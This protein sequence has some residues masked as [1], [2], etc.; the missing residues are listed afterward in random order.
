MKNYKFEIFEKLININLYLNF[1]LM[2][3]WDANFCF[4]KFIKKIV[5]S[6]LNNEEID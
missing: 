5:V 4:L 6:A 3:F 2:V 1:E